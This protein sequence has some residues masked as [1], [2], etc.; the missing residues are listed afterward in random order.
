[1]RRERDRRAA[2]RAARLA[3]TPPAAPRVP[4]VPAP[5]AR[6]VQ[7]LPLRDRAVPRPSDVARLRARARASA[8][9]S[10]RCSCGAGSA[11]PRRGARLPGAPTRHA[12]AAAFAGHRRGGRADPAATCATAARIIVHG[13][14]DVDGVC[15]TAIL[16]ARAARARRRRRLVPAR[17]HRRR[18][19]ALGR[20]R[21][22]A[23]RRGT[24]AAR[25]RRLRRSPPSRRSQRARG[26]RASTSSS[27]TTTRRAPTACC[28]DAPIV[29]PAL[30]RL[31]VPATCARAA[32]RYKLAQGA[33]WRRRRADARAAAPSA[34]TTTSTS[35][36][37]RRSPTCVPLRGENRAL[38]RAGLRALRAHAPSPGCA[39]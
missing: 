34:W 31:P 7:T 4:S 26:A 6:P 19:R 36:R 30:V 1:M 8:T 27:P 18:L 21:R 11:D 10:R 20:D 24:R 28:R 5:Y 15:S 23:R 39:R 25:H 12:S 13:D 3:R 32:S 37:S 35:S 22:A 16:V 33:R 9:R 29:H 2:H 38:V 14:Y 17:P